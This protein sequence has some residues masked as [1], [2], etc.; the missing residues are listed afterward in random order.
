MLEPIKHEG[1][2]DHVM[3]VV[4]H[5][6]DAEFMCSGSV[7]RWT[8]EGRRVSYV[9]CTNG[10]KGSDDP[11]K[12]PEILAPLRQA[13]Q[14][15]AC[16]VLGVEDVTFLGYPDGML[17]NML[18]L[19][20]DL[21]R[22]IRRLRPDALV[23]NDPTR[24]FFAGRYINHP[25]HRAAGDAALDAA[26]P[27]A[28]DYHVY[29]DLIEQG[30]MPHKIKHIYISSPSEEADVHFDIASVLDMKVRAL[31]QH[32]SQMRGRTEDSPE[33]L[34]MV[35][36][37]ARYSAGESGLEYAEAFRYFKLD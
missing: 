22:Q 12:T 31:H 6:D 18:E 14:R 29:P 1:P 28:R 4:A 19:R 34:E 23:C 8:R 17:A 32:R 35:Q 27:S 30:L 11:E 9:L 26:F 10:D 15:A 5:P 7:A 13:E 24:R 20:K 36:R 33:A 37:M 2:G 3:V 25:D 16:A 21:V